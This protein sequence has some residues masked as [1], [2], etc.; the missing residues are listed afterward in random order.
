MKIQLERGGGLAGAA[1]RRSV[2]VDSDTLPAD[3]A[4]RLRE[5]VAAADL[6]GLTGKAPSTQGVP[7]PDAFHYRLIV[8]DAG[9][10][11][12]IDAADPGLSPPL[13]ALI[14]WLLKR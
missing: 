5:L 7:R 9:R 11:S 14:H 1:A 13:S 8:D 4:A 3:E 12:R 2:T 6:P 10:R